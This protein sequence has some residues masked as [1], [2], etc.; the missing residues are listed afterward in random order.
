[1]SKPRLFC[2]NPFEFLFVGNDAGN[3][4][5]C[6]SWLP[7][8]A[9]NTNDLQP[10]QDW[11]SPAAQEIRASILDGSF[12][13]CS[14]TCP[15]LVA[16][17]GPVSA[18]EDVK[19]PR[20]L[21]IIA[22]GRT[23]LSDGPKKIYA[24]YDR[25]CNLACPSCRKDFD[26][27]SA[28]ERVGIEAVQNAVLDQLGPHVEE[29][30][31]TGS[32]DPF[33]SPTFRKLLQNLDPAA[34]P[35]LRNVSLHTNA[36]LWTPG[37]WSKLSRIHHLI[38]KAHISVDAARPETYAINRRGGTLDRL[39]RNL[40]FIATLDIKV[41]LSF[42]VQANNFVEMPEFVELGRKRFD[43]QVFFTQLDDW[44][45]FGDDDD[46]YRR[47]VHLPSHPLHGA[48]KGVLSEP[49]LQDPQVSLG[50]LAKLVPSRRA[51]SRR[52]LPIE[53]FP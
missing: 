11:N 22:H 38:K 20:L 2:S 44:G 51:R 12:R 32:G 8:R 5:C 41:T 53:A 19:D 18:L 3:W 13:H 17:D 46:Y 7:K 33:G 36:Q 9:G 25:S 1:M 35:N 15:V 31:V 50:N 43:F 45:A 28:P 24:C 48:L 26:Q 14:P 29:L 21:D 47:A 37:S 6:P 52:A 40:E 10:A 27:A 30:I 34:Y 39:V 16:R 4:V 49:K 42:V 23:A